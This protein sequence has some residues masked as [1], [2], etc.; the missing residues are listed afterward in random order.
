MDFDE[1]GSKT[2]TGVAVDIT[3]R[4]AM[5]DRTGRQRVQLERLSKAE[6]LSELSASLAHE[7][8]QPLAMILTNAEAAQALLAREPLNLSELADILADIVSADR[9]A[10]EVI[11]R[12]RS[13]VERGEPEREDMRL[14]DAIK[15]VLRLVGSDIEDQGVTL[16]L[17]L[18]ANLPIVRA[19]SILT[20]QALLN[21]INNACDAVAANRPH[22]RRVSIVTLA[23][24][25]KVL[26]EIADNGCGAPDPNRIFEAFYSTKPKGLGIG[27]TI[28]RSIVKSHGG[29][30]WAESAPGR[31]TTVYMS[32]PTEGAES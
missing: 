6:T 7:L 29:R 5:L 15:R 16:D 30:V 28:V 17:T 19:D 21:L 9:R 20:E 26:V 4:K 22:E 31:G 24:G 14:N 2:L 32:L 11:R 10:A 27:L 18:A 25:D 13:L 12:L 1:P 3:E 8:N 23:L